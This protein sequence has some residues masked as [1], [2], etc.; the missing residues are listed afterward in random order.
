MKRA[1][2]EVLTPSPE[3][4]KAMRFQGN[5][6]TRIVCPHGVIAD[7]WGRNNNEQLANARLMAAA[8]LLLAA[9]RLVV[10]AAGRIGE[11]EDQ[12]TG[13]HA[14]FFSDGSRRKRPEVDRS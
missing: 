14:R 4:W 2:V 10:V 7:V 9:C 3:P 6:L 12:Q 13:G 1:A 5:E 8:P 11:R